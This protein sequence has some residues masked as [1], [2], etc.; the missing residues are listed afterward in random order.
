L[1]PILV[2]VALVALQRLIELLIAR[3]NTARLLA[4][5]AV[6]HGAGQYPLIVALHAAWLAALLLVV[7][8]D[9]WPHPVLLGLFLLLQPLRIW[10]IRSLGGRWTTRVIVLPGAPPV[11]RGPYRWLAHP[12]YLIVTAEIALLPLAFGA[13]RTALLFSLLNAL[14]LRVRL[15]VENRALVAAPHASA[16]RA[17]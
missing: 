16:G 13:W 17:G 3:R 12:N 11:R 8:A 1:S 6:E 5:G 4:R 15:A 7:P 14:L 9:R 10:C 2:V